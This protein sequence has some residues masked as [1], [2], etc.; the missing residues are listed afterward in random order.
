MAAMRPTVRGSQSRWRLLGA[1]AVGVVAAAI[2]VLVALV[3]RK[4]KAPDVV[5]NP[6][7]NLAGIPQQGMVLGDPSAKVT[8]IEYADVQCP[9]CRYYT[10]NVFPK[11]VN[12]YVRPGKIKMEYRGFPF[13]SSDSVKA[14]RFL[15]AA[16][17][18]SRMW[19]LQEA[20]YRHQGAERSGWVTD[21]LVRELAAEIQGL[22]VDRLFSDASSAPI[23]A[24]AEGAAQK[25]QTELLK[26]IDP[27]STPSFLI[28]I[29]D[30]APYYA[31]IGFDPVAFRAALD[32]ALKG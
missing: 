24:Q 3:L 20:L 15:L 30:R 17:R 32:D 29:D 6:V 25:A 26:Y 13:I 7:V 22:D 23:S 2:L 27:I 8:L 10:L 11:I 16:G 21:D 28:K 19:Q 31:R 9:G 1:F 5:P 12:Q 4:D 14:L 18:Q